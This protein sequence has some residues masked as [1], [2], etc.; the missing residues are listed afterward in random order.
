MFVAAFIT[1]TLA[2]KI[3]R[4]ARQAAQ[5]AFRTKVLFDTNQLIQKSEGEQNIIDV[6]VNQIIG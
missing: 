4:N 5:V 1:S 6:T 3:K 2:T